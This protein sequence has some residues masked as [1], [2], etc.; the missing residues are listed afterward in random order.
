VFGR[1]LFFSPENE[2][3]H[4]SVSHYLKVVI[5]AGSM[6]QSNQWAEIMKLQETAI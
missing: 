6:N 1:F 3:S 4:A 5:N 2:A